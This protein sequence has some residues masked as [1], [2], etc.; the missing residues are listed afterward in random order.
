MLLVVAAVA[1]VVVVVV[2]VGIGSA[3]DDDDDDDDDSE[4]Y[5][6]SPALQL[7]TS[8]TFA[9]SSTLKIASNRQSYRHCHWF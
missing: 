9:K 6:V 4:L 1:V 7:L 3:D 8:P 5:V 2:M